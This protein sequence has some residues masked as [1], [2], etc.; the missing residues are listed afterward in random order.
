MDEKVGSMIGFGP[1]CVDVVGDDESLPLLPLLE[2][3]SLDPKGFAIC[4]PLP[5]ATFPEK[6]AAD[7]ASSAA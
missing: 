3:S 7:S 1:L 2:W 6:S 5:P 4:S